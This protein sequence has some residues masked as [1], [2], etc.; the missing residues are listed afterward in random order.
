MDHLVRRSHNHSYFQTESGLHFEYYPFF[1]HCVPFLLLKQGNLCLRHIKCLY[2]ADQL[3]LSYSQW[4]DYQLPV[5]Q[6]GHTPITA[7]TVQGLCKST[8]SGSRFWAC[9][10]PFQSME[11][12]T[13]FEGIYLS[14]CQ[15]ILTRT[16]AIRYFHISL[17]YFFLLP[18]EG[19][20]SLLKQTQGYVSV[21]E[22]QNSSI[23]SS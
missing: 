3:H 18:Q 16:F 19:T 10:I 12:R 23:N 20:C 13:K 14:H 11:D 17:S 4:V 22:H 2:L 8:L 15:K 6:H 7:L 5:E 1:P 9:C 21:R